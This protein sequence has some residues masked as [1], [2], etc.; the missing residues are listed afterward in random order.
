MTSLKKAL[1]KV[2]KIIDK[3]RR[4][5]YNVVCAREMVR[6]DICEI[7]LRGVAQLG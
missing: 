2:E 4:F 6:N 7:M 5:I 1:K 3:S